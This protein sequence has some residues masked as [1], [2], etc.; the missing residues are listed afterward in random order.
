M[1]VSKCF[2]KKAKEHAKQNKF[3]ILYDSYKK[4]LIL[5]DEI[6]EHQYD[7]YLE[8]QNVRKINGSY[9]RANNSDINKFTLE[10][11]IEIRA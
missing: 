6:E 1:A 8:W 10:K 4:V 3:S 9:R 7:L 2:N 11:M 5:F